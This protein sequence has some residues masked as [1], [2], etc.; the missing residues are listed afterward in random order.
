MSATIRELIGR[1]LDA[2]EVDLNL[3]R[4]RI[5]GV[6][7]AHKAGDLHL[8]PFRAGC[9][10]EVATRIRD[11]LGEVG[12]QAAQPFCSSLDIRP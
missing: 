5:E 7:A 11:R 2:L 9:A 10:E 1:D 3:L 8:V 12:L 4:S 6:R